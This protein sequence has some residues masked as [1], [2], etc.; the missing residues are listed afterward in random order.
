MEHDFSTSIAFDYD[1][2]MGVCQVCFVVRF[3]I[4]HILNFM[5]YIFTMLL[6]SISLF[7]YLWA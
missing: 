1:L 7:I 6:N 2:D 5:I 4:F 3:L